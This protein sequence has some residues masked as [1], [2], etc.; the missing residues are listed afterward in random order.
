[1]IV[2]SVGEFVSSPYLIVYWI[3]IPFLQLSG[4][5]DH[6]KD[7]ELED[8]AMR[9]GLLGG[10]HGAESKKT[11]KN[12]IQQILNVHYLSVLANTSPCSLL[13]RRPWGGQP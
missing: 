10:L 7:R 11:T 12:E 9:V 5:S 2:V 1:M 6:T 4:G 3:M 8:V 13:G